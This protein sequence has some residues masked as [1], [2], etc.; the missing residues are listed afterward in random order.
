MQALPN[1]DAHARLQPREE[2]HCGAVG[3]RRRV[4]GEAADGR[5]LPALV[6]PDAASLGEAASDLGGGEER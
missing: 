2:L 5:V 6:G 1:P 4:A 3:A